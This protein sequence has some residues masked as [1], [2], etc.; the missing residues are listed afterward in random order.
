MKL[1]KKKV[2]KYV[3]LPEIFPRL[4]GLFSSGF[5]YMSS[6]LAIIYANTGLIP[7]GHPYLKTQNFGQFGIR[8]V[9][10]EASRNLVYSRKNMDQILMHGI[11]ICGLVMLIIQVCLLV[12]SLFTFPAIAGTF[13]ATFVNTP[14][15]PDQDIA[16]YVLDRVFGVMNFTGTGGF[17]ESCYSTSFACTDIRGNPVSTPGTFP[18][19][20]HRALH[21]LFRFYTLGIAY[22]AMLIIIYWVIAIIGETIT[23]GRPFG[24]RTNK[25]WFIPRLI[26][27]F[28]LIA[29]MNMGPGGQN[30]GINAAQFI[31]L[32]V[33]K[34]GSNMATNAWDQ[35]HTDAI[36]GNPFANTIVGPAET[37][38]AIPNAPEIG[39]LTQFLFV[40][41]LC[42]LAEKIVHNRDLHIY[43]V[44]DENPTWNDAAWLGGAFPHMNLGGTPYYTAMAPMWTNT[45]APGSVNGAP[46][47]PPSFDQVLRWSRFGNVI[48]RFGHFNPPGSGGANPPGSYDDE[49][50]FVKPVCGE[51][52]LVPSAPQPDRNLGDPIVTGFANNIG[53]FDINV[54]SLDPSGAAFAVGPYGLQENYFYLIEQYMIQDPY[55]DEMAGCILK[56][57]LPYDH[58]SACVDV[59]FTYNPGDRYDPSSGPSRWGYREL[60]NQ[61]VNYYNNTVKAVVTG[62]WYQPAS[63]N[64]AHVVGG[65]ATGWA[66]DANN[67][68]DEMRLKYDFSINPEIL[69]RGWVG[70]ALWYH[71]I[72]QINGMFMSA[73][74]NV[75]TPTKY[76]EIMEMIAE[77]Q[78]EIAAN[79]SWTDR[80]N[81]LLGN[82][83]L[84][85]LP[86]PGDQYIAAALHTGFKKWGSGAMESVLNNKSDNGVVDVINMIFGTEGLYDLLESKANGVHPFAALSALGKGMIDA[87]IRNLFIGV[88]GQGVGEILSDTFIGSLGKAASDVAVKFA[89]M[90][91]S[92]GFVLYYVFP[93]LPFVYFFFAFSGWVKSI[94]EA[95]V[96]MP[97]WAIAHIKIDGEGLPG[98]WA[99][100]GYFLLFEIFL[101]PTLIIFGLLSSFL[102]FTALVDA[103]NDT[104][105]LV[106]YN[107]TGF[108]LEQ[109]FYLNDNAAN[110]GNLPIGNVGTKT[111]L[112]LAATNAG[113]QDMID[114]IRGPLD[115]FFYTVIYAIIIYMIAT[116]SFKLI[117]QIPNNILRWMGATV[118]TFQENAGDPASELTGKMYRSGNIVGSQL[119]QM[120]GYLRGSTGGGGPNATTNEVVRQQMLRS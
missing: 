85:D 74:Q 93:L 80:F 100:N 15:G 119:G 87:S 89:L 75:P 45:A 111:D 50:G 21:E 72:A 30:V 12:V 92:I 36:D 37:L 27:F 88:V 54:H 59:D 103:V 38:I 32:A 5:A 99:T 18:G 13:T 77:Q 7:A 102:I 56:S 115:E 71:Y 6:L 73:I 82:G 23:S 4:K 69:R 9:I 2:L 70:A 113:G 116:S 107:A 94:F 26:V 57:I 11:I 53:D 46:G 86:R 120:I 60:I 19:S 47:S 16:F 68:V 105:H 84:A 64:A 29:P 28:A 14:Y 95:I 39:T 44:R 22:F 110:Y 79:P 24:Q 1:S 20:F 41:R 78:R 97:L 96:A 63:T 33:A 3:L 66:Y 34:Y 112:S 31:T 65:P 90:G 43:A 48:L 17:F 51:L 55:F 117:D 62:I 52:T 35:F 25:A 10:A 98:P 58:D 76:P 104:F 49:M 101:R 42:M 8:H 61:N 40:A 91:L 114:F 83:K 108:E 118:S 67:F 81:P 106:V 109:H